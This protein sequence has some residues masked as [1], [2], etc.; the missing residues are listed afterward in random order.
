MAGDGKV[1][2]GSSEQVRKQV[3]QYFDRLLNEK[4]FSVCDE[5]LAPDYVDHD[6]PSGSPTGPKPVKEFV[7]GF[8]DTYPDMRVEIL[9][10]L[11]AK[12]KAA[13]RLIWRGHHHITGELYHQVG[14][15]ILHLNDRGQFVERWSVYQT[16]P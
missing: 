7:A 11:S 1:I 6:A 10:I 13:A 8:L 15:I 14:I 12:N 9:E 16:L 3:V 5:M 4:D 2:T